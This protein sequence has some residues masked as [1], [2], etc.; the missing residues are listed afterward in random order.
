L[1]ELIEKI[2]SSIQLSEGAEA[3]LLSLSKERAVSKAEVLIRQ[4][5]TVNKIFL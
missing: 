4:G 2:K 5:Q 3:Y 1:E